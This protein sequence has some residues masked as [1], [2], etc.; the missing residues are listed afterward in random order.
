MLNEI[1]PIEN[2]ANRILNF[3][4]IF[5][6]SFFISGV[7]V[8]SLVGVLLYY[9]DKFPSITLSFP[10]ICYIIVICYINGLLAF[11]IGKLLHASLIKIINKEMALEDILKNS[12]EH[13]KIKEEFP[14]KDYFFNNDLVHLYPRLWAIVRDNPQH[15]NSFALL[16][17]YWV[18]TAIYDGLMAAITLFLLPYIY[19]ISTSSLVPQM[20]IVTG[21]LGGFTLLFFVYVCYRESTRYTVYQIKELVATIT[22][23]IQ[24]EKEHSE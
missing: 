22:C 12:I 7:T 8:T 19:I 13:H 3:F 17:R 18:M 5:D 9:Q 23:I 15:K 1:K 21:I 14:I 10:I 11:A 16:H 6:L 24:E 4:D 20:K 2:V